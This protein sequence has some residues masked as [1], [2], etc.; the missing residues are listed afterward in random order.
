MVS[1][2]FICAISIFAGVASA[3]DVYLVPN[4]IQRAPGGK[5][6]V[7]I[8][9]NA[10]S[11]H[12]SMGVRVSFNAD[13]LTVESASKYEEVDNGWILDADGDPAT[14]GDQ[15]NTPPVEINNTDGYVMMFG[16]RLTGLSGDRLL[17]WIDFKVKEDPNPLGNT[18]LRVD[19][20]KY[21]PQ[22]PSETFD[23]FV[24][25]DAGIGVKD[26]PAN[27]PG[28][29]GVIY[30]GDDACEGEFS[31]DGIVGTPDFAIISAAFGSRFGDT[32]W[33]PL[34]DLN[35]DGVIGTPDFAYV[36]S[37]FGRRDCIT[38]TAP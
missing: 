2:V 6:R 33:N 38:L 32:N 4:T 7:W 36:S 17:G 14:T 3:H 16:G 31:G 15:Y 30:V 35:N 5:V 26:E 9:D 1:G 25:I 19:L 8:H 22:D 10:L 24:R 18:N 28:D 13:V 37:D 12:I 11:N 23:N 21:H 29:L 34:A 20:A 27:L